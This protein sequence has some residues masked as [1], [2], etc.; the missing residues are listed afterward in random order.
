MYCTHCGAINSD[1]AKFYGACGKPIS[2]NVSSN[3]SKKQVDRL[4][5]ATAKNFF[6]L[7]SWIGRG[8]SIGACYC[9]SDSSGWRQLWQT[10]SCPPGGR[11][12]ALPSHRPMKRGPR[13]GPANHERDHIFCKQRSFL[14][15]WQDA[16]L[17]IQ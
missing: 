12:Y 5:R 11:R 1:D 10:S 13:P 4:S 16:G 9:S 3:I 17:R 15:G 7:V 6:A 8:A 2:S 14:A